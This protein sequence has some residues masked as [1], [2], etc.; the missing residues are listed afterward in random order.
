MPKLILLC[1]ALAV[2]TWLA[3]GPPLNDPR[4]AGVTATMTVA[5]YNPCDPKKRDCR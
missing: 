1:A 5:Q 2:A 3:A 4:Q